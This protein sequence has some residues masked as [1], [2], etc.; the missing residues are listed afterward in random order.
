LE[1]SN[2]EA[3]T[4]ERL[5]KTWN[6]HPSMVQELLLSNIKADLARRIT[7]QVKMVKVELTEA[8]VVED[9]AKYEAELRKELEHSYERLDIPERKRRRTHRELR[10]SSVKLVDPLS[11]PVE[12]GR[13]DVNRENENREDEG[14]GEDEEDDDDDLD[15]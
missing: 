10:D 14:E 11:L 3:D 9:S 7:A 4:Y 8:S 5:K 15:R 6:A 1:Q 2:R 13:D 12:F